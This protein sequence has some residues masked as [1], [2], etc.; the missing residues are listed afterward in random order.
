MENLSSFVF[1][2]VI[3]RRGKKQQ[4]INSVFKGPF[5]PRLRIWASI[6]SPKGRHCMFQQRIVSEVV[7]H[8]VDNA[9]KDSVEVLLRE[10]KGGS[11]SPHQTFPPRARTF[12]LFCWMARCGAKTFPPP[13]TFTLCP[14]W[15][16]L[17]ADSVG[18]SWNPICKCGPRFSG[19]S[20][21]LRLTL[22]R[23]ETNKVLQCRFRSCVFYT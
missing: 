1:G 16:A 3:R 22:T 9:G 6:S 8:D 5:E 11:W 2:E 12:T 10:G 19:R 23:L 13:R 18:A 7:V 15:K 14:Y 4:N 17:C 20:T 21:W